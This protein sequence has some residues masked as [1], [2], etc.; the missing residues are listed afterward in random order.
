VSDPYI[1]GF[2][3]EHA[4]PVSTPAVPAPKVDRRLRRVKRQ[5]S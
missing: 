3:V 1:S 4:E 5:K 2:D